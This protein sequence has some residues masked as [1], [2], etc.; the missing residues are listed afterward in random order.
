VEVFCRGGSI[1]ELMLE[2]LED[3]L[4]DLKMWH[5]INDQKVL[6]EVWG[7]GCIQ[8]LYSMEVVVNIKS[9]RNGKW[10]FQLALVLVSFHMLD[11]HRDWIKGVKYHLYCMNNG[12]V[13]TGSLVWVGRVDGVVETID[14]ALVIA[15]HL[16]FYC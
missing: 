9:F 4:F 6:H 1:S 13:I 5:A 7:G 14:N 12:V 3:G 2:V 15:V 10:S 11:G 8:G 16:N